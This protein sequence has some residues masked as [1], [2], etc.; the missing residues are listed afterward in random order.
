MDAQTVAT[1][2]KQDNKPN[3]LA[4]IGG[5]LLLISF[6]FPWIEAIVSIPGFKLMSAAS[7][8]SETALFVAIWLIP[9]GGILV[10]ILGYTKS[11]SSNAISLITGLASLLILAW[12][13]LSLTFELMGKYKTAGPLDTF[14]VIGL[15]VYVAAVGCLTL[16]GAG[17]QKKKSEV[18]IQTGSAT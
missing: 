10:G 18:A 2:T 4:I 12:F 8:G 17:A 11:N 5:A 16:L 6:F 13:Y 14:Q 9:V 1:E 15:G 7:K 3:I